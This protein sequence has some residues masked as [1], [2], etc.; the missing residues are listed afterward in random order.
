MSIFL[1]KTQFLQ[2]NQCLKAIWLQVHQPEL[3]APFDTHSQAIM[4]EG[5]EVE[6]AAHRLFPNG[7]LISNE[8][9]SLDL[10]LELT[11]E[12]LKS[13]TRTI[14]EPAFKYQNI[15]VRSDILNRVGNS[16]EL[17]EIKSSSS[18]KRIFF[19]DMA[20]QYYVLKNSGLDIRKMKLIHIN[21]A[22][23]RNKKLDLDELFE[24]KDITGEA[25]LRLDKIIDKLE[26]VQIII[27]GK[28]PN[29]QIGPHCNNPY[30]CRFKAHCWQ[31]IPEYSVFNLANTKSE[32]KFTLYR[33]NIL[34][35]KDV[36]KEYPLQKNAYLQVI[37]EKT[38]QEIISQNDIANF[39]SKLSYPLCFLDFES[40]QKAIPPFENTKPYQQIPFQYSLH[41]QNSPGSEP[42]H[43]EFIGNPGEDPRDKLIKQ[44][45]TDIPI[46]ACVIGYG[47]FE[48]QIIVTLAN[49]FPN[50]APILNRIS[51]SLIDL[52]HVFQKKYYYSKEMKGSY[53]IKNVL[54]ALVPELSYDNLAIRNGG[55]ANQA[56]ASLSEISDPA[57]SDQ[58]KKQLLEYCK[59]DTLAMVK[60]VDKL[61]SKVPGT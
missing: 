16:Y 37:C 49:Q 3:A 12:E 34:E 42:E 23:I 19:T 20:I 40:F 14:F 13:G 53:S 25:H 9:N 7:K 18:L 52:M 51:A 30:E 48:K 44:L 1:T 61:R 29:I 38:G 47:S 33:K 28:K 41:V 45:T 43:F 11:Q 54:P 5:R 32:H 36:P 57:E 60:I 8:S 55:T 46:N 15:F 17:L 31:D 56:Y 35:I 22:Y 24:I 2:A 27:N 58:K 10:Q 59:L 50:F 26:Q 6:Y 4:A 39:L 21:T